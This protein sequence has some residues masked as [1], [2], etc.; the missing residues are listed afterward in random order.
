MFRVLAALKKIF[1]EQFAMPA[2]E[3]RQDASQ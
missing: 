2:A 1:P 3:K